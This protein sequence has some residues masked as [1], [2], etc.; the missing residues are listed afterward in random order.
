MRD[1]GGFLVRF[2]HPV[3]V[4]RRGLNVVVFVLSGAAFSRQQS[5]TVSVRKIT[6]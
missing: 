2:D 6:V 1:S 3:Q 4:G 5:A